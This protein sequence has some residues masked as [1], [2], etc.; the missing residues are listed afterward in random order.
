MS[1]NRVPS[2]GSGS[3]LTTSISYEMLLPKLVMLDGSSSADSSASLRMI[4]RL[5]CC[6]P[7]NITSSYYYP[8]GWRLLFDGT[9]FKVSSGFY[10]VFAWAGGG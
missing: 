9:S 2:S 8:E 5:I 1:T 3:G 7:T 6:S 10:I 4:I